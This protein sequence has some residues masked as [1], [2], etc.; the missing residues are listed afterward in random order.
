MILP[1]RSLSQKSILLALGAGACAFLLHTSSVF[2][3]FLGILLSPFASFP[4]FL[5]G[6]TQGVFALCIAGAVLCATLGLTLGEAGGLLGLF[7]WVIVSILALFALMQ[8]PNS[9][10]RVHTPFSSILSFGLILSALFLSLIYTFLGSLFSP[11][12]L[13]LGGDSPVMVEVLSNISGTLP[14]QLDQLPMLEKIL[15]F[16]PAILTIGAW[17]T[18]G[19]NLLLSLSVL[20]SSSFIQDWVGESLRPPFHLEDCFLQEWW[21]WALGLSL[22]LWVGSW[23]GNFISEF[24]G[25]VSQ[26]FAL[27]ACLPLTI[28][29]LGAIKRFLLAR[30]S[31]RTK[32]IS[33]FLCLCMF[34]LPVLAFFVIAFGVLE[35][36]GALV[37]PSTKDH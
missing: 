13:K 28:A 36:A 35:Y 34:F 8:G 19:T 21:L 29:G 5:I 2:S 26:N 6:F 17:L 10:Q 23:S 18:Y 30:G 1:S 27:A 9:I 37:G 24:W 31:T 33:F 32:F 20:S 25:H 14:N 4:L 16:L 22:A 12:I 7:H 3:P 15:T 11:E